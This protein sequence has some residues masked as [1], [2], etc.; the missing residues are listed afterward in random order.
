MMR[1]NAQSPIHPIMV[2]L[3]T[4]SIVLLIAG[5]CSSSTSTNGGDSSR[6]SP[7]KH[8]ESSLA[9]SAAHG[10]VVAVCAQ[11]QKDGKECVV[12]LSRSPSASLQSNLTVSPLRTYFDE[13]N[14]N[15][16]NNNDD[17]EEEEDIEQLLPLNNAGPIP[18]FYST[19][20]MIHLLHPP[21]QQDSSGAV[22]LALTG[23]AADA[24]HLTRLTAKQIVEHDYI[25][26]DDAKHRMQIKDV[27]RDVLSDTLTDA[28]SDNGG[29][30][31]GVQALVAGWRRNRR[32]GGQELL[33]MYTVDPSGGYKHWGGGGT[34]VGRN[35][36]MVRKRLHKA[37]H[38]RRRGNDEDEN[39]FN[40]P[41]GAE[42]GLEV[43]M[44]AMLGDESAALSLGVDVAKEARQFD[45]LVLYPAKSRRN[46]AAFHPKKVEEVYRR[47]IASVKGSSDTL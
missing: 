37:L 33:D 5:T 9:A 12:I 21:N 18:S 43:A 24:R 47:Y 29:R 36:E 31:Y 7:I 40:I 13:H 14:N 42:G 3:I 6:I 1:L 27:V 23:L 35:A 28:A 8:L 26:G 15:D 39:E 32:S 45:A 2:F 11:D 22:V 41:Q 38:H 25:Y 46:C 34:A 44:K 4:S 19:Q 30:P 10:T 17:K 16:A 20:S